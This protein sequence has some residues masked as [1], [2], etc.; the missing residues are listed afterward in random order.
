MTLISN[1]QR[2]LTVWGIHLGTYVGGALGMF[3]GGILIVRER[4]VAANQD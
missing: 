4:R 1:P 3:T 2:F